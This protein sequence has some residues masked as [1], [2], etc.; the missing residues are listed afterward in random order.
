MPKSIVRRER[1]IQ[2]EIK[3]KCVPGI[4]YWGYNKSFYS[5]G[6]IEV[7]RYIKVPKAKI[8]VLMMA[9]SLMDGSNDIEMIQ[10]Q[11]KKS[12][13]S[14]VD[15][16]G[17][18]RILGDAGLLEGVQ[19]KHNNSEMNIVGVDLISFNFPTV[20]PIIKQLTKWI[21]VLWKILLVMNIGLFVCKIGWCQLKGEAINIELLKV[22][23]NY[24]VGLLWTV[25]FYSISTLLH[26]M[27][28]WAM[29]INYGL[30][31]RVLKFV[32]YT[33]IIPSMYVK[34]NGMYTLK[35]TQRMYIMAAGIFTNGLLCLIGVVCAIYSNPD[36]YMNEIMIKFALANGYMAIKNLMPFNIS[37]GYYI[38]EWITNRTNTRINILKSIKQ[39]KTEKRLG[40]SNS[41]LLY[42][43]VSMFF[44]ISTLFSILIWVINIIEE[45]QIIVAEPVLQYSLISVFIGG[46][47]YTLIQFFKKFIRYLKAE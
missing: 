40:L 10:M 5:L 16:K 17:L 23:D 12:M 33:G 20:T 29:A 21:I 1:I 36:S 45:I 31:P 22:K 13:N 9:V 35:K 8:E 38:F 19:E 25:L 37:D 32:V 11:L 44:L 6:S 46:Y 2:E 7:D 26:E 4:S 34:I 30:Q 42:C 14:C 28:H 43:I 27:S 18:T 39:F 41:V 24:I 15:I 3:P 47:I